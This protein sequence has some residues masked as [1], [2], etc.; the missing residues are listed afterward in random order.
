MTRRRALARL[1]P[2]VLAL[3]ALFAGAPSRAADPPVADRLHRFFDEEWE[4]D[5]REAPEN[6][7]LLGD[8]RFDDR[9]TDL[10]AEAHAR[11][12]A[13]LRERLT[14]AQA[15]DVA[16]LG[17]QDRLS[18]ELFVTVAQRDVDLGRF[19]LERL[20]LSQHGGPHRDLPTLAVV[21]RFTSGRQLRDWVQRLR[22]VP[23]YVD[24][25][26]ALLEAGRKSGWV[27]AREPLRDVVASIRAAR[28]STP[29]RSVFF[30]PC[31]SAEGVPPAELKAISA[32]AAA[33][34]RGL[35]DPAFEKLAAYV[36]RTYAPS[37]RA[38]PGVWALP[39]GAAY[40]EACIRA[41]T[42]TARTADEIHALGLAEVRRIRE[43]MEAVIRGAG[44]TGGRTAWNEMLRTDPR[45]FYQDG[46]QLLVAY[47][48]IA[49]RIDG[50]L[51]Q[52]FGRLPR[53]PY[54]V[55]ETPAFE[56]PSSTTAYYRPGSVE[57]GRAGNFVANTWKPETR[58]RWE[59]EAL[60]LHEAV[61]GHHLQIALQQEL[62]ELPR[63]RREAEFTAFV[64]GWGLYAESLGPALGMFA[65]P[66]SKYGQL[67]YEM[68]R[69]VRLV[70]DTG[71]HHERWTR[72]RAIDYFL[73]NT[74]KTRHDIE[75]E[76]DRYIVWPGQ[77]L[78]YKLGELELKRLR[79]LAEKELGARFDVRR[80]H[81]AVLG[82]GALPLDLLE[83]RIR[84]FVQAERAR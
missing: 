9:L 8:R 20:A 69:A 21:P 11:R 33:A 75:V 84:A 24:Q 53:L 1:W 37:L 55:I 22:A 74:A 28:A 67:T 51:P 82:A 72:Q 14:R 60:T 80:F 6:A 56:A 42:T 45:F 29:E 73:E 61:P 4:W 19:P 30:T 43:A 36:E 27:A 7:T 35:V 76:V 79:A 10:S 40:Y 39:D 52:L 15:F 50:G 32:E 16:A 44:F 59:M 38:E 81:D 26:I 70:V 31:K 17:E 77:A 41:H 71:L 65:D 46:A 62:T 63:F 57:D 18:L 68:W 66:Y 49:K 47:R 34:I 48:D 3:L 58:P 54:G 5:L 13:H 25:T 64:E 78:A 12:Q 83:R 2:L 23:R